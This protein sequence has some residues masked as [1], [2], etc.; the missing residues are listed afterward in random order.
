VFSWL[1][2]LLIAAAMGPLEARAQSATTDALNDAQ[3]ARADAAIGTD[4]G[5]LVSQTAFIDEAVY[6][7]PPGAPRQAPGDAP[8]YSISVVAP[9]NY[10]SNAE[11]ARANGTQTLEGDP[12]VRLGLSKRFS[13]AQGDGAF[14]VS[15]LFAAS[16]DRFLRSTTADGD[17]A[18]LDLRGQHVDKGDDQALAPFIEYRLSMAFAP[19]FSMRTATK[20]DLSVGFDKAF[21]YNYPVHWFQWT[22]AEHQEDTSG[23]TRWSL[24]LTGELTRRFK[25]SSASLYLVSAAPSLTYKSYDSESGSTAEARWNV[26]LEFDVSR[27]LYDRRKGVSERDWLI[28]PILTAEFTPPLSLFRG[29]TPDVQFASSK[30]LGMP[31]LQLQVA[32]TQLDSNVAGV[33]FHQWAVGP[34]IKLAW[35]F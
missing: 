21:N 7:S 28:D 5:S 32:F 6:A 22:R 11:S 19:T 8:V 29:T 3:R 15:G 34:T 12:Q 14:K 1:P 27:R 13:A 30:P 17:S 33:Q 25:E 35:S 9:G 23:A 20:H 18:Y 26:S 2:A 10:N 31:K 4:R 16:S 24:G